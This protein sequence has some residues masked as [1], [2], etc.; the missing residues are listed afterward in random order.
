[1][2]R[3]FAGLFIV[4]TIMV[5]NGCVTVVPEAISGGIAPISLNAARENPQ[6]YT[7]KQVRLGGDIATVKSFKDVTVIEVVSRDLSGNSRPS[8]SDNTEGRFL[9]NIKGFI[10]PAIYT[11]G[12]KITITGVLAGNKEQVIGEYPYQYPVVNV[13]SHYLWPKRPETSRYDEIDRWYYRPWYPRYDM[14]YDRYP[15]YWWNS[16]FHWY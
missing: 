12:R 11:E 8:H 7:G 10:D 13:E 2:N 1:M 6:Q 4:F 16:P 9:A 14:W 5:M 3:I 15:P